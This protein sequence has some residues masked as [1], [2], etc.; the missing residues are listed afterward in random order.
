MHKKALGSLTILFFMMGFITC[1]ND[2]LVPYLKKVFDL[3]YTQAS[4]IQFSFFMAYF[5]ISIPSSFLL[6]KIGYKKSMAMGFVVSALGAFM[7][8]PSVAFHSYALFLLSLFILASGI[9]LLQ[10]S[11]NPYVAIL[12]PQETASSRLTMT[13]AFNSFGTFLAPLLGATFI[14]KNMG[15][16]TTSEAVRGP[17]LFIGSLLVVLAIALLRLNLPHIA[18]KKEERNS[19]SELLKNSP[20]LLGMLGIFLYVGAEVSIGSFFVNFI[21]ENVGLSEI[22]ASKYVAFY[23]GGAM[24]GRFLGIIT[25]KKFNPKNVLI[26]HALLTLLLLLISYFS[27]SM[28]SVYSLILVG[29]CNSIMFP[30][31]FTLTLNDYVKDQEKVSGLLI[32]SIVGGAL[33][34][35][36]MGK[37]GDMANLKAALIIPFLCYIY[38]AFYGAYKKKS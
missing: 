30:T 31:I 6:E 36:L 33:L 16:G 9:V 25:L 15:S 20:L 22:E 14:L 19:Y 28:V 5:V 27:N 37:V 1:L 32:T 4:L 7:F 17:Y 13:Q 12:G 10:V 24:V 2:I 18:T 29:F 21:E 26:T 38:I 3:N 35:V 34:P 11:G 8:I 23:W